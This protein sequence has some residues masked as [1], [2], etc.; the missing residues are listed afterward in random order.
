[1]EK[2]EKD[3][4]VEKIH[5]A[6]KHIRIAMMTTVDAEGALKSRPMAVQQSEFDGDLWFLTSEASG[7]A[8][9][10]EKDAQ[11]NISFADAHANRYLS[12]SGTAD[13][14]H[15]REKIESFWSP[16]F[17]IYFPEGLSDPNLALIRVRVI[18]AAWWDGPSGMIQQFIGF[19]KA[20]VRKDPAEMGESGATLV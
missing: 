18:S 10:I 15:D 20:F 3:E 5:D 6:V 19:V 12:V 7:K 17:E 11:V 4:A 13:V 9:Q 14:V 16:A 2:L 8:D 1:M